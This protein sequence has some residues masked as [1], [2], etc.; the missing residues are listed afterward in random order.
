MIKFSKLLPNT[1]YRVRNGYSLP[2]NDKNRLKGNVL[3]VFGNEIKDTE[4]FFDSPYWIWRYYYRYHIDRRVATTIAGMHIRIKNDQETIFA[5]GIGEAHPDMRLCITP[6]VCR[7]FNTIYEINQYSEILNQ[8]ERI[9]RKPVS[10]QRELKISHYLSKMQE[11]SAIF[12]NHK[13]YLMIP[14]HKFIPNTRNASIWTKMDFGRNFLIQFIRYIG[15]KPEEFKKLKNWTFVFNNLNEV[16]Y[17]DTNSINSETFEQIK[18]MFK[19]FKS[20]P[21]AI[22]ISD[23][24]DDDL[25][26]TEDENEENLVDKNKN[27]VLSATAEMVKTVNEL[28]LEENEKEEIKKES[29]AK[30]KSIYN[31]TSLNP[32]EEVNNEKV[33]KEKRSIYSPKINIDSEKNKKEELNTNVITKTSE[34]KIIT[35]DSIKDAYSDDVKNKLNKSILPPQKS[36]Q[37]LARIEKMQKEMKDIKVGDETIKSLAKKAEMK[38]LEPYKI[39]ADTINENI[40]YIPFNNFE[41]GYNKKL[42]EYDLTNILTSFAEKDR[43][44]YLISLN[45]ENTSTT[46][47]KLYTYKAVFEDENGTRHNLTFDM[48]KM[49]D[50]KFIHINGSDKLFVNQIIP[51]PITKVSPDEVQ[52]SS[53]YNKVFIRRFGR[54]VST[55]INKFHKIVPELDSKIFKY[56]KGNNVSENSSYM[57]TI[58]YDELSSKYSTI[59]LP[60]KNITFYFNQAEIRNIINN[61]ELDF[62]NDTELPVAIVESGDK[63]DLITININSDTITGTDLSLIDYIINI[64]SDNIK[65]FK[66]DFDKLSTGKK[67]M[68]TRAT[69]MAKK[70]PMVLLLGYPTGLV[71][72]MERLNLEYEFSEKRPVF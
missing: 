39:K 14:V 53:S 2:F 52:V 5:N 60:D 4:E 10:Q 36:I 11:V 41:K 59:Y 49:V 34:N 61:Y 19:K 27:T 48:P 17:I 31:K 20:R 55:K 18:V 57:T 58:E 62:D 9:N 40:K 1:L 23:A 64:L 47:D 7:D 38:K 65:S 21:S 35:K 46:T 54:N 3:C 37:R 66:E 71:P 12:P 6:S 50:N 25:G 45:K 13:K 63:Q 24:S 44:L 30:I 33:E 26:L 69:I 15:E 22:D 43:P 68:Y 56:T 72:L 42:Y 32:I 51:L 28:P 29:A 70:V 67:F 16:F 8:S